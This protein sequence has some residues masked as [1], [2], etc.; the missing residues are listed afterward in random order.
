MARCNVRL[1]TTY[2]TIQ[3]KVHFAFSPTQRRYFR[4][5]TNA[6]I[7]RFCSAWKKK[8]KKKQENNPK[9]DSWFTRPGLGC[10]L[11]EFGLSDF[12]EK[13]RWRWKVESGFI[14]S[15]FCRVSQSPYFTRRV[16]RPA[17]IH[18]LRSLFWYV[19]PTSTLLSRL[20]RDGE[21]IGYLDTVTVC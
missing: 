11:P 15:F 2:I 1:Q 5:T 18:R 3:F 10:H 9:I 16:D 21:G 20:L 14:F 6:Y 7:Q 19:S 17:R 4:C 8:T 13:K 12:K